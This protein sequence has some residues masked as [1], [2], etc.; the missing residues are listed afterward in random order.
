MFIL[1][2][3]DCCVT[4]GKCYCTAVAD[5]THERDK[6]DVTQYVNILCTCCDQL[7]YRLLVTKCDA[8]KV[9]Y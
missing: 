3:C 6:G 1:L 9:Q 8:S 2:L 7:W 5:E 4:T